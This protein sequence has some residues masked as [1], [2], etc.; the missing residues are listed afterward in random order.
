V[1]S[2][3][4]PGLGQ[5]I[6]KARFTGLTYTSIAVAG[7]SIAASNSRDTTDFPRSNQSQISDIGFQFGGTAGWLSAWDAFHR[8]VP[9][10]QARGKY[11][12]LHRRETV[13]ELI[14]APLDFR[15]LRRWT[16]WVDLAQTAAITAGVLSERDS[17]A[18]HYPFRAQDAGYAIS[19]AGNAALGEEAAF[20]GY[21]L[22]M[23]YQKTGQRFWVANTSQALLFTAGHGVSTGTLV[24][25]APW[26]LWEGWLVRRNDWSIR[27]SIFHHFWYDAAVVTAGA[28]A[29]NKPV[30]V[31][32]R[33]PS[34]PF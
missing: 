33:F 11:S 25:I 21:L 16:T 24:F 14:S 23:L 31:R 26:A 28:I 6:H 13:R 2:L 17:K 9:A 19:L 5:Y 34:I 7:V 15:F 3:I 32:I 29:E 18:E 10:M 30:T 12:F 20:R 27:E 8:A 1:G 4:L 22:P